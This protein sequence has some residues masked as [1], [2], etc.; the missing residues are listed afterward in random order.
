MPLSLTAEQRAALQAAQA[1][2]HNVRHWRRFQ[3]VLRR[4]RV[5]RSRRWHRV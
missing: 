4:G 1:R 2:S 5:Y 3:A